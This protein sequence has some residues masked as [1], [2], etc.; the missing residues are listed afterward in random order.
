MDRFT[1]RDIENLC[2]I[3]AHTLRIWEQRYDFFQAK[4][5]ESQHRFYDGN[6]LRLLLQVAFL[7]HGGW[8]VSRI[9]ALGPAG[10]EG[11]VRAAQEE[12]ATDEQD[13]LSLVAAGASFDEAAFRDRLNK[14]VEHK[15]VEAGMLQVAFPFLQRVGHLWLTNRVIPAQEHFSAN[16]IQHKIIAE[17]EALPRRLPEHPAVLL[18]T[19]PDEHHELPLLFLNY[20]LRFYGWPVFYLGANFDALKLPEAVRQKAG[21]FY[22]HLITNLTGELPDDYF[23]ALCKAYPDKQIVASGRVVHQA[24]R[25]FRNLTLLRSDEAIRQFVRKGL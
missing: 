23:E 6:D 22:L 13:I 24:Q 18:F 11:A 9:A 20:L 4:R 25:H 2:R 8:K 19:P 5:K 12:P 21:I 1:I 14:I 3:K 17:T 15:G 10:I 7:Y 16:L